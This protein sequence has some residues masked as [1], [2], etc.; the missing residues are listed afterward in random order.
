MLY[1]H[2]VP[3][4]AYLSLGSNIGDREQNLRRAAEK[5]RRAGEIVS[6]SSV[7]ETEPVERT[8][9]PWFLNCVVA[10]NTGCEPEELLSIIFS[11]EKEMGRKRVI[12][13]GPRTID[14][15]ILLFG[16]AVIDSPELTIPHP[17][18]QQRSFVL[19]PLAEVAPDLE[20]PVLKKTVSEL[21]RIAET[22]EA[23][24]K[25]IATSDWMHKGRT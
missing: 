20:H 23:V 16:T 9:Q 4:V 21:C 13:K 11:I 8:D 18:M 1:Y 19:V 10:V 24:V 6:V 14:L 7:Y 22:R 15:D 2:R 3:T 12:D 17:A 5:L 25:K